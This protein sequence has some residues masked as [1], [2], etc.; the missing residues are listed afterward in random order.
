MSSLWPVRG[1]L[2]D[3][4]IRFPFSMA[5]PR[6]LSPSTSALTRVRAAGLA[7]P[8]ECG[9]FC[10]CLKVSKFVAICFILRDVSGMWLGTRADL[11]KRSLVTSVLVNNLFFDLTK[12]ACPVPR[13]SQCYLGLLVVSVLFFV[14]STWI[15]A[16]SAITVLR[17]YR[18]CV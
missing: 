18:S 16:C 9:L 14:V 4:L 13:F 8:F 7:L 6:S 11:S 17:R 12:C 3:A 10:C 1:K 15:L 2:V 5:P